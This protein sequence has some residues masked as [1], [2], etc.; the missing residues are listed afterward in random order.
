M[1]SR[2]QC[3]RYHSMAMTQAQA[4][5]RCQADNDHWPADISLVVPLTAPDVEDLIFLLYQYTPFIL[6]A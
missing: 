1:P 6:Y 3:L 2:G 4:E 5:Q